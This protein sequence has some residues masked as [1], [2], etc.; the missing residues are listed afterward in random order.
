MPTKLPSG[1]WRA[2]VFIGYDDNGKRMYKSFLG[3]TKES[4]KLSA[5][6]FSAS[7]PK[8][9]RN[10]LTLRKA[11]KDYIALKR[12]VLSPSTIRGYNA[13]TRKLELVVP[14]FC[15]MQLYSIDSRS[16]QR[17]INILS[18]DLSAKSIANLYGFV[19][20]VLI[21][22]GYQKP[23]VTLPHRSRP[24]TFIPDAWTL[25]KLYN[26][27]EGTRWEIPV[28]LAALG[29]LRRGEI[30]AASIHDLR[31]DNVFYIHRSAVTDET[32]K[33]IIKDYPKTDGSNRYVL[34]PDH[35]A[36]L[37]RKQGYVTRMSL[38]TISTHF[39]DLLEENGIPHFRFHD[40]RHAF[41]SMAHAAGIPDAY[42]MARGGWSTSYTMNNVYR[43]TY[44]A[45]RM[46]NDVQINE[47]MIKSMGADMSEN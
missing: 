30:V 17:A 11:M 14:D 34:L 7:L 42:I 5:L 38:K 28:L 41:V 12:P 23:H 31:D 26:T 44:D 46:K 18:E 36:D 27:I 20:A 35:L 4:A 32:G 8:E 24:E 21:Q 9:K 37:I 40:L 22:F 45:D 25:A 3:P 47:L 19:G 15:S 29:P 2:Q 16:A 13:A 1:M 6:Q 10:T 43:H 33:Q 39:G